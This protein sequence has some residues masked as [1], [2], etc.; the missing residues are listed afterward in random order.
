MKNPHDTSWSPVATWYD[1]YLETRGDTYHDKVI[2]PNLM[3]IL[4]PLTGVRL[5][6]VG[7]GQGALTRLCAAQGATVAGADV[8]RELIALAKKH[9]PNLAYTVAPA[10]HLSFADNESV[11][12]VTCVLA[13]QNMKN[14][15]G[16][17]QEASRVA[18]RGGRVVLVLN[19]PAFRIPKQSSWGFDEATQTQYRRLDSYLTPSE[20]SIVAHPGA[21]RS[22]STP[23]YHHSLQ[24]IMKALH[25]AGFVITRLEEWISHKQS[26]KGPRQ[27][28]ED[29]ARKEF[30]LFMMIEARKD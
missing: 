21:A 3:R 6:D 5:L 15:G 4:G 22:A 26:E 8:S 28:A 2:Y 11:D 12:L 13:L 18:K 19:H 23:S 17:L 27:K 20:S 25:R 29:A 16:A 14:L 1:D 30:P 10:D 7:C 24:D 9:A